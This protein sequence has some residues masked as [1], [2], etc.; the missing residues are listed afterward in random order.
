MMVWSRL[1]SWSARVFSFSR[2]CIIIIRDSWWWSRYSIGSDIGL[3]STHFVVCEGLRRP[4]HL[5]EPRP[6]TGRL[7]GG[8]D[9]PRPHCPR[10]A[11]DA[12]HVLRQARGFLQVVR[13]AAGHRTCKWP[14][15]AVR[16]WPKVAVREWPKVAVRE[17][18]K[19]AVREWPKVAFCRLS[20]APLDTAPMA[21]QRR[22]KIR[23]DWII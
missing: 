18:P 13:G 20:E 8:E 23:K 5:V 17:W 2:T 12:H 6:P 10:H 15:V 1:T 3:I 22:N 19:V 7:G 9:G 16:E 14:K 4:Q 11:V 21:A